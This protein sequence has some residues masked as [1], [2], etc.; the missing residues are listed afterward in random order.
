MNNQQLIDDS[1]TLM[2]QLGRDRQTAASP[3]AMVQRL[4][5]G[6]SKLAA[7]LITEPQPDDDAGH[8]DLLALLQKMSSA[9]SDSDLRDLCFRLNVEYD[10]IEGNS[11]HDKIRELVIYMQ[12][13]GRLP[14]LIAETAALRPKLD[15][16]TAVPR[17]DNTPIVSKLD[18]AVV[19]DVA[20]P[21]LPSVAQYLDHDRRNIDANFLVFRHVQPGTF[22]SVNDNWQQLA[23][24]FGSAMDRVQRDFAGARLHFFLAGPGAL[25]FSMGCIWGTVHEATVYHYEAN[26]FHPVLDTTRELRAVSG[27][28]V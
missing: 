2:S 3:T 14:E 5:P 1:L 8:D 13:R 10:D 15:W 26:T 12:R 4:D 17:R 20:R 27:E 21:I 23:I 16:Q 18:L 22:F 24:T 28:W 6:N 25:L 9:F 19:I 7:Y 11:R